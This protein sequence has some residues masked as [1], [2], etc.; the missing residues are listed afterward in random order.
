MGKIE[1]DAIGDDLQQML[2]RLPR[3][4][5]E[6]LQLRFYQGL[7]LDEI[8]T[9]LEIDLSATKMRLYRALQRLRQA[10]DSM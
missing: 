4:D 7:H 3:I 8:A 10:Y 2:W 1:F 6:I 5:R 9:R